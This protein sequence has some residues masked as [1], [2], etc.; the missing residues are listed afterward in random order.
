MAKTSSVVE[1]QPIDRLE[2][3][4]KLLVSNLDR[5]RGEHARAKDENGRLSRDLDAARTRIAELEGAA[6]EMTTLREERETIRTRVAE[7]LAQI[8]TLEL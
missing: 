6:A 1:L 7:M 5:L 3:K 2:E 8:E 4:V